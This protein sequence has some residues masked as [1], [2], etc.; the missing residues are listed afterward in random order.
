[1]QVYDGHDNL[2]RFY[3]QEE[4]GEYTVQAVELCDMTLE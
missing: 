1:M 3:H 2:L 4:H